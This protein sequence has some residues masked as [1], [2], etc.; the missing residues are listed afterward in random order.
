MR[1][2][3]IRKNVSV[4]LAYCIVTGGLHLKE[5]GTFLEGENSATLQ[6]P[7]W[8]LTEESF[9]IH[10]SSIPVVKRLWLVVGLRVTIVNERKSG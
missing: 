6:A 4:E 5:T 10:W 2:W 3:H 7:T 1:I 8:R 9:A